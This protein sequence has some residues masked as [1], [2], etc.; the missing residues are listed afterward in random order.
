[1]NFDVF[2]YDEFHAREADAFV[3]QHCA[4]EGQFRIPKIEHDRGARPLKLVE[5]EPGGLYRQRPCIDVTGLSFGTGHRHRR[6]RLQRPFGVGGTDNRRN[7]EFA[8]HNG[9]VT[10]ASP[11]FSDD[12]GRNFHD[13]FPVRARRLG[14]QNFAR[15]EFLE[16][17]HVRD[18]ANLADR[19]FLPY[20]AAFGQ[21]GAGALERVSLEPG[22]RAL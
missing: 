16:L 2:T 3:G 13:R 19:N 18:R 6:P 11:T 14:N 4:L 17:L 20:R 9:G 21:N 5:A 12:P 7:A 10:R 22:R 15:F 1:M 8:G